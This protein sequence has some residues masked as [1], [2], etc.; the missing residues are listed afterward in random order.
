MKATRVLSVGSVI[1]L[2]LIG[3]IHCAGP[4]PQIAKESRAE[5]V[6]K[7]IE[8]IS[9]ESSRQIP[10]VAAQETPREAPKELP[11][12]ISPEARRTPPPPEP[13]PKPALREEVIAQAGEK[14]PEAPR[15]TPPLQRVPRPPAPGS[16]PPG[17]SAP[18]AAPPAA[19]QPPGIP[20]P[21]APSKGSRFVL[22]FDN[23]DIY[24][25]IRVMGE[26]ANI[27]YIIDPRVKGVVNIRTSGQISQ[28][29]IVPVLQTI[30][31]INGATAV[32]KGIVHEIVPFGEA[33]KLYT[34]PT[35]GRDAGL[36]PTEDKYT[37]QIITL[38]YIP[39]AEVSKMIK[40]FLSDGADIVEYPHHNLLIVGD[41]A[42]NIQ[43]SL[44]IIDLFDQDIFSDMR[45]RIY[46]ILNADVNEV[47]K[48]MER[49]FSSLEV[50]L[51]S[52]RGVGITFTPI[53]R[54]NS[55]LAVSS[56]PGVFD[57][58]ERWVKELDRIPGEGTQLSVFVYYV[59]NGKAKDLAEVLKQVYVPVKGAKPEGRE[60]AVTSTT[61]PATPTTPGPRGVRPSPTTP[62]TPAAG[63]EEGGGVPEGEIN[64]VVD[65]T[66]NSLII[67][68]YH[69]D[70]RAILET[71]RKLDIYPKQVL[72]EVLLADVTLDDS[73]KYGLEWS[74]FTSSFT[75]GGR[76]YNYSLG[77]GGIAPQVDLTS[78]LRYAIT[79]VDRLAAAISASATEDRLR[80]ISSPHILASNNKEARIQ[81][82]RSEPILTNTYTTTGTTSPGVVEGTIEY[83]DIGIILTVTPRIS[84]GKLVTLDLS[85]EQST[86]GKT[87]LGNLPDV[88]FFP[89]KTAKTTLSIMEKQTIVIGGLIEDRKENVKTGIPYLSKIPVLGALFGYHTNQLNKIETVL[90]LTPYVVGDMGDSQRVTEEFR[91][92]MHSVQKELERLKKEKEKAKEKDRS[93]KE[94]EAPRTGVSQ[95]RGL[96]SIPP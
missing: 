13:V 86:V 33:K 50:S 47:S 69:R 7:E 2:F 32:Q 39:S 46:P 45:V 61:T 60:R 21:S 10:T 5:S 93:K 70:Y 76:T 16:T 59:Q 77:A 24:E 44:D 89:K 80:V 56:I 30:L 9:K 82:G 17:V 94:P 52:G 29:D 6:S 85:V 23:A 72:I 43:K 55:L 79:S 22:N 90:F 51:K 84:D 20:R 58:V 65:E 8:E 67:R 78:G 18:P 48:E 19:S 11:A 75:S 74:V 68:A 25:V 27:N 15:P 31:K 88:P 14:G 66:T 81:V 1:L 35:A 95:S 28:E 12:A 54:I 49:I 92:K 87:T 41:A 40:P 71:I 4:K 64:I 63:R 3:T 91:E 57:K 38:K 73:T 96:E 34:R 37:I 36:P 83:K 62:S 42:S 53:T 26:M